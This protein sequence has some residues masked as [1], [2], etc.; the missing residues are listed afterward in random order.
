MSERDPDPPYPP[1][2]SRAERAK[3]HVLLHLSHQQSHLPVCSGTLR[4]LHGLCAKQHVLLHLPHSRVMYPSVHVP[5]TC[6]DGCWL[7]C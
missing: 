4:L 3:Q 6:A 5:S 1:L 2:A 7:V